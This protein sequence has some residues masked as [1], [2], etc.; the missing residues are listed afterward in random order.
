MKSFHYDSS[1]LWKI[2]L[3]SYRTVD[4]YR[5]LDGAPEP[6]GT[7]RVVVGKK[8]LHYHQLY[9]DRPDP[10]VFIPVEVDTSRHIYDDFLRLLFLDA[11][12][13]TSALGNEIPEE[14]GHFRFLHTTCLGNYK[15]SVGLILVKPSV[16]RIYPWICHLSPLYLYHTSFDLGDL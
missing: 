10:I 15:G 1:T 6:D 12:R 7:L 5:R 2:T 8:I 16:M 4:K 14:S 3:V 13:E 9:L 11:H